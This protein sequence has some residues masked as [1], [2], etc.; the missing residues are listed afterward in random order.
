[1]KINNITF[2]KYLTAV[3]ATGILTVGCSKRLDIGPYQ[4]IAE[5]A[6]LNTEGDVLVTLVGAYD[7][8]QSAAGWGGEIM[9]LNDLIGNSTNINFTGTFA[10]LNDAYNG[11]MVSNNSFATGTWNA[12]YSVINRANNVLS[13]VGKVTSSPTK[14]NSVEGEALFIRASMY[15]ELVRLY[16]KTVGDGDATQNPG[17]PL[18]LTPTRGVTDE[19]YRARASVKAVYDQ[20]IADLTKAESLLPAS[21][22]FYANKWAAAAML[23]RVQLQNKNYT[24]AA[25]AANRVIA[26]SGRS[27]NPDFTKLWF[28]FINNAGATPSEYLFA[29][30]VTAQDGANSIN[31]YFGRTI[32]SIPGTAG[33]SDCKIKA[34]HIAQY[35]AGDKRNYFVLSGGSYYS[36]KHLD[37]FGDVPVIRLAEMYLTRAEANFRNNTSVGATPLADVNIVR[38]R[39][40]LAPLTAVTLAD[41]AKERA[42]EL[43]FE[44]HYLHDAKRLQ[45]SV[46]ALPWNSPKLIMPIPQ[47]EMDVNKKLVQNAGY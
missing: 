20:V 4:S 47:R 9:V 29:V 13:A 43:A 42:L 19:D 18:V 1:M 35:E 16:A 41:I 11:L 31:T 44:G 36:M 26:G 5:N 45:T 6:A 28:T 14:K 37:R 25:A 10:G 7:G 22:G 33:R 3:M 17:V 8:L 24:E 34:A 30:K 32:S 2:G 46:G 23:A 27:L 12:A 38:G 39:A 15:F 40:G 21:N